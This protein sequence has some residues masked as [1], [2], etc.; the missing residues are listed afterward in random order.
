MILGIDPGKSGG[1]CLIDEQGQVLW[2][3]AMPLTGGKITAHGVAEQ[4]RQVRSQLEIGQS[5]T[6]VIEKVF[7]KPTDALSTDQMRALV[8]LAHLLRVEEAEGEKN[9]AE[10]EIEALMDNLGELPPASAVKSDGRVGNLTY[11]KG[12]GMLYMAALWGWPV[13]EVTPQ[14]WCKFMHRS[15]DKSMKPKDRSRAYLQQHF[16][17]MVQKGSILWPGKTRY[18]HEGMMDALMVAEWYRLNHVVAK[19]QLVS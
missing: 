2:A 6:V 12:A 1:W 7:T 17:D 18:P 3:D 13:V 19:Q 8:Q 5:A 11:A 15:V 14:T 4:F 10:G 9:A 16:P